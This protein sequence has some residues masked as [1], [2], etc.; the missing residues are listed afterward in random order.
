MTRQE[1]KQQLRA[2]IRRMEAALAPGYLQNS[3]AAIAA[4]LLAMPEYQSAGTIFC[5]VGTGREIDTRPILRHALDSGKTVCVPLCTTPGR[6]E[7][8]RITSLEELQP[9]SFG[10]PEPSADAPG[11]EV[12][13][14][15][16]A[17]VP[18]LS[19]NHLGQ[20]LGRGGGY[21]DRYLPAFP[22]GT[23]GLCRDA[24]LQREIPAEAH[25]R[26]VDLVLTET[27]LFRRTQG[28]NYHG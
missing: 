17:V 5:F 1:E 26:P 22:G 8:R 4:H 25:D 19:C 2:V 20:R 6:M 13:D 15:D 11:V 7:L 3:D 16:L 23:V 24:L 9:G 27:R 14:V 12:D 21:Y 28:G 10:I 18:C